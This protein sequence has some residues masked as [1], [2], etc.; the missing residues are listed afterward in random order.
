MKAI[1]VP[2]YGSPDVLQLAEVEKPMPSETQV[3]VKVQAASVNPLDLSMRGPLIARILSGAPFKPKN[4][5]LGADIAGRVEAVGS[6]VTRFKPGDE[7]FGVSGG[8]VGAFAEYAR[9]SQKNLA[10]KPA[11]VSF[12]SAAAVPVAAITALQALRDKGQIQ[13]GQQVLINGA[14]G[15]VGTFAIQLAKV[16]GAQVTAV[17]SPRNLEQAR[18]LGADQ[19]ID[20]TQ[21]NFTRNGHHYDLIIA[22]NGYHSI[23]DYRRALTPNGIYVV[24]G[25]SLS[26]IFQGLLLGPMLSKFGNQ[27][28][29]FMGI[30]NINPQD[31][32]FLSG[33]LE[34]G[35]LTPA[36]EAQ[37]PLS[38][39]AKAL[40]YLASG[41]A[42]GK[43][44]IAIGA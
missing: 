8:S 17:C 5:S 37:Y 44:V 10:R 30:A 15:G 31:L 22:A 3:L 9:T 6:A 25:G 42:R 13:A 28:L 38:E 40:W 12:Q 32:D 26:Q 7:V 2:Q 43:V 18:Q 19:V 29:G 11:Q 14:S 34:A 41:H 16:F 33:L 27:K 4:M 35:K 36:V 20:Y 21:A 1:I 39:T 24:L 23:L